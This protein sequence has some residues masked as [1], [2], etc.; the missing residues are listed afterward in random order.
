MVG[1]IYRHHA[2]DSSDFTNFFLLPVLEKIN[3]Q[4]KLLVLLGHL[5]IDLIKSNESHVCNFVDTLSNFLLPHI[6][7]PTRISNTSQTLI[8]NIL[9]SSH[10]FKSISGNFISEISDHLSQF[11]IL[12]T[13]IPTFNN[14]I[15][16]K[17]WKHFQTENFKTNF[18]S[19]NWYSLMRLGENNPSLSFDLFINKLN[20]LVDQYTCLLY[21]SPSPRDRG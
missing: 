5:N 10:S 12:D 18:Q 7:L 16:Y 20:S 2:L 8:D 19:I 6:N 21:T 9:I 11:V 13:R 3:R 14:S 4:G 15:I 17:A 1:S